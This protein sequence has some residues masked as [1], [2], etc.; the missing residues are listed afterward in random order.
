MKRC[1]V[2][3]M[4]IASLVALASTPA[5]AQPSVA[6]VGPDLGDTAAIRQEMATLREEMKALMQGLG[7][8]PPGPDSTAARPAASAM[9]M[10]S[11]AGAAGRPPMAAM[12]P[13]SRSAGMAAGGTIGTGAG[14]MPMA[15]M[16]MMRTMCS[17]GD[18]MG[19]RAMASMGEM[20]NSAGMSMASNLPGFPGQSH[21]YHVGSTG[22]FL[23]HPEH[24]SLT[25]GQQ[26]QLADIREQSIL[27]GNDW[28]RKIEAAEERLWSLTG[29]DQP[30]VRDIEKFVR[31][32]ERLRADQ[33]LAVI[34]AVGAAAGLL[35]DEQ[36]QQ[37]VGMAPASAASEGH[38]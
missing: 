8:Q 20:G 13:G 18:G 27:Q 22:F 28:Q 29:A 17:P 14:H 35:T 12:G 24:I 38:H 10:G 21:L 7:M 37:L 11:M 1:M 34:R 25:M 36:R 19:V 2:I 15:D 3:G 4:A 6:E 33:R 30:D 9:G 32:I 31:E 26:R 23:D 5:Q 16:P